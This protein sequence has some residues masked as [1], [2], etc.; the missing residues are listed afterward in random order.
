M[1]RNIFKTTNDK[2]RRIISSTD[3]LNKLFQKVI[4]SYVKSLYYDS[5]IEEQEDRMGVKRFTNIIS[6]AHDIEQ[7]QLI[8]TDASYKPVPYTHLTLPTICS[9]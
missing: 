7:G 5:Q 3:D 2:N 6:P 4:G 8:G 1:L 9:V